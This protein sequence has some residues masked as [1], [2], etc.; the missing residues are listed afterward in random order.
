[1]DPKIRAE[2]LFMLS[3]IDTLAALLEQITSSMKDPIQGQ[4][5][6]TFEILDNPVSANAS[7]YL[8]YALSNFELCSLALAFRNTFNLLSTLDKD[9]RKFRDSLAERACILSQLE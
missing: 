8:P 2:L 3:Q 5:A 1:M 7:R 6:N 9:T 4:L